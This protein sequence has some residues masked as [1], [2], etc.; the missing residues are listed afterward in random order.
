[1]KAI[2][3]IRSL[4]NYV[5]RLG[6]QAIEQ[7]KHRK[8]KKKDKRHNDVS[9]AQYASIPDVRKTTPI[10]CTHLSMEYLALQK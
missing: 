3:F 6:L 10:H 8:G 5:Q 7:E 4:A 2:K 9:E 1:M